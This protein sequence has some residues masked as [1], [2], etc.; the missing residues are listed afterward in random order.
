MKTKKG[1]TLIE[2]LVVISITG[3]LLGLSVFGM[4]EARKSSRDAKRKADLEQIRS[5][6]EMYKADCNS[7]PVTIGTKL[8]GSGTPSNCSASNTYIT[9]VPLDPSNPTRLYYYRGC[10]DGS[11]YIVCTGLENSSSSNIT[12]ITCADGINTIQCD[13]NCGSGITCNY[14]ANNP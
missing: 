14:Q 8:S 12:T 13:S 3:I 10:A 6:V 9:S 5:G 7:Y 11:K 1:F 4:Q 2:L